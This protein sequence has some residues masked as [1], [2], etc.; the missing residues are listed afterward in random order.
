MGQQSRA[1]PER[2]CAGGKERAHGK[3][4]EAEREVDKELG[5]P[6]NPLAWTWSWLGSRFPSKSEANALELQPY[7]LTEDGKVPV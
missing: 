1:V 4:V 6:L 5:A 3:G 7:P 2:P